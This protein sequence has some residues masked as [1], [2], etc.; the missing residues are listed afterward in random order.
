V[1]M[2]QSIELCSSGSFSRAR[3]VAVERDARRQWGPWRIPDSL[4]SFICFALTN[5]PVNNPRDRCGG[6]D[7]NKIFECLPLFDAIAQ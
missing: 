5:D 6:V 4:H 1:D 7:Y 3:F 2:F